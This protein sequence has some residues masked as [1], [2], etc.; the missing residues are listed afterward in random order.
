MGT[1]P[2]FESDFDCLTDDEDRS[3]ECDQFGFY[4][5]VRFIKLERQKLNSTKRRD[6]RRVKKWT[7]MEL[8]YERAARRKLRPRVYK[9]VPVEARKSLWL[10]LLKPNEM[11]AQYIDRI[12][13][14]DELVKAGARNGQCVNQIHLD[15]RRT[16]R[17]HRHFRQQY[18]KHQ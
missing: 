6:K 15:I 2:I 10:Y 12:T 13:S 17:S 18:Q 9:G 3:R 5:S 4:R 14:F 8:D 11:R 16:W 7:K 1:H